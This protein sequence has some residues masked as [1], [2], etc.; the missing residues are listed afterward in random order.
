M[1]TFPNQSCPGQT[2]TNSMFNV[3]ETSCKGHSQTLPLTYQVEGRGGLELRFV[4][5]CAEGGTD[6]QY[7]GSVN[8][9][10][11]NSR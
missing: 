3:P 1:A 6:T 9:E 7:I 4:G 11:E 5:M 10:G 8:T 2:I